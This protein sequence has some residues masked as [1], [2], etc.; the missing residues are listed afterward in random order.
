MK[1]SKATN[2][3]TIYQA[4]VETAEQAKAEGVSPEDLRVKVG[5]KLARPPA[6]PDAE[7]GKAIEMW[8]QAIAAVYGPITGDN[9]P[10]TNH[11]EEDPMGQ[12]NSTTKKSRKRTQKH[13]E[14]PNPHVHVQEAETPTE[15]ASPEAPEAPAAVQAARD[16]SEPAG[17]AAPPTPRARGRQKGNP[18]KEA[19]PKKAPKLE[20]QHRA[21]REA[22]LDL[23]PADDIKPVR[24]GTHLADVLELTA[25]PEGA[26]AVE[27]DKAIVTTAK[28]VKH[29]GIWSL[30][31]ALHKNKGFGFRTVQTE[32]EPARYHLVLPKG[33]QVDEFLTGSAGKQKA[34]EPTPKPTAAKGRGAKKASKSRGKKLAAAR[35]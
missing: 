13:E 18:R 10:T 25:R 26:T 35:A 15:D 19:K 20:K 14:Q 34:T 5:K 21:E 12:A 11:T 24:V 29:Y 33:A 31:Y 3:K 2:G 8:E 30:R 32:G 1:K 7:R 28:S 6:L 4:A 22:V 27:L 17:E 9:A 16:A 23:E